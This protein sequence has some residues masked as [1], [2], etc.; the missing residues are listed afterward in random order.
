[1]KYRLRER[2][3]AGR[4]GIAGALTLIA[5][6]AMAAGLTTPGT[7]SATTTAPQTARAT[8]ASS[9][10]Q[11][12]AS[13]ATVPA[14]TS[15]PVIQHGIDVSAGSTVTSWASV[16]S[17]GK[18]FTGVEAWQGETLANPSFNAEVSGA[19]TAGLKV[20]PYV[21]ANPEGLSPG[22]DFTGADQF[23]TAW[24][25]A[26]DAVPGFPYAAGSQWLPVVLDLETDTVNNR[27]ECYGK[28]QAD[29]I[30]WIQSFIAEARAKTGVAPLVYVLPAW[31]ADCTG[32]STLFTA[33]PLWVPAFG[34]T[35]P[36]VPVGWPGYSFWQ[37]SNAGSVSGV[38]G[39]VDLDQEAGLAV[40]GTNETTVAGV[41]VSLRV[42]ASGPDVT[43]GYKPAMTATGL[44]PGIVMDSTGLITGWPYLPGT[45][46]ITVAAT[47][48]L[49][50]ESAATFSWT[51]SAATDTGTTGTV[52]QH[53]GSDKCLDDPGSK[54]TDATP[55]DLATC[56]A[57]PYQEWTFVQDGT[58]RV[59][60]HC[61]TA[62]GTAVLLYG[63]NNS[64]G[65]E[66]RVSTDG[67]LV[68]A[69]YGT[70]LNGPAAAVPN[71]T[72]LA[73]AT[74]TNSTATVPQHWNIPQG[75]VTF[76]LAARC[77]G[78]AGAAA[79]WLTCANSTSQHW[80]VA[81]SAEIAVQAN[82]Q[83]LTA[84]GTTA[85]AAIT[86]APCTSAA[87]QHWSLTSAGTLPGQLRNAT[88]NLCAIVPAG[89]TASGTQLVLGT[90]SGALASTV[91]IA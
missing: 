59:L 54:V 14:P 75:P 30:T 86:I 40:K 8:Q 42:A 53:G 52:E 17:A 62:S 69:R 66:W 51:V 46:T 61:L 10:T 70:C 87:T 1:V 49:T 78:A 68:S 4:A 19:I 91:R 57:Q 83:C 32:N 12:P 71:G 45:Y 50:G 81:S 37:S 31:W 18:T 84:G 26:I 63:C 38:T 82:S 16:K 33:D 22:D 90:C 23:D 25:S 20:M 7:A 65:E 72:R 2:G 64:I 35:T 85:G 28:S 39:D 74:C 58:I 76:G 88:S 48:A 36:P 80:L 34:V 67:S 13:A 44:P 9:A 79:E 15:V 47:D 41:P 56:V 73:L 60:G 27:P 77:L 11:A 89:A 55:V 3:K 6:L 29:M 5:G 21:F 24:T 43:A